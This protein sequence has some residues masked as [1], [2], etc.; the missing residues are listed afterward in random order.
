M[1]RN[2]LKTTAALAL[3]LGALAQ[4]AWA[5]TNI[6]RCR[7]LSKPGSYKLTKNLTAQGDCFVIKASD[8]ILDLASHTLTGAG[9]G[10]GVLS[11][12]DPQFPTNR[13]FRVQVKNGTFI[14][15]SNGVVLL[16]SHA[17]TVKNLTIKQ[18]GNLGIRGGAGAAITGN[19]VEDTHVGILVGE[20][21]V[22]KGNTVLRSGFFGIFIGAGSLVQDNTVSDGDSDGITLGQFDKAEIRDNT[23]SSNG[24]FGI[25]I[26]N[27]IPAELILN[28]VFGNARGDINQ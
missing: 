6:D 21:A 9:T 13:R 10:T 1:K 2:T 8:V 18:M 28:Q 15:F 20:G 19:T 4:P 12:D 5:V 25:H 14:N 23:V 16:G 24:G 3:A 17:P 11:V 26:T 7:T 27:Q 22:V